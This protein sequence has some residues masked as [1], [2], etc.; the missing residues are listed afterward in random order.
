MPKLKRAAQVLHT[1]IGRAL[2]LLLK[3]QTA[4]TPITIIAAKVANFDF[5]LSVLMFLSFQ[6]SAAF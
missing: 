4:A 1:G 3:V 5:V 2:A 6:V